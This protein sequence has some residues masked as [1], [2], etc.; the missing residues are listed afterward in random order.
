MRFSMSEIQEM[1]LNAQPVRVSRPVFALLSRFIVLGWEPIYLR[2]QFAGL[3]RQMIQGWSHDVFI[4]EWCLCEIEKLNRVE[5]SA[6][7]LSAIGLRSDV[8]RQLSTIINP[9]RNSCYTYD[10]ML[11]VAI[12]HLLGQQWPLREPDVEEAA[13]KNVYDRNNTDVFLLY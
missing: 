10:Q 9:L 4:Y 2:H 5:S 1:L 6:N 7:S 3:T 12:E 11:H 13:S 8:A